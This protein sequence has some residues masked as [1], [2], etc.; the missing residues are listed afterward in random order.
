MSQLSW[1]IVVL[2]HSHSWA[3]IMFKESQWSLSHHI[4]H[5]LQ[6][7]NRCNTKQKSCNK[8]YLCEPYNVLYLFR[9]CKLGVFNL[10][11]I[12]C[13]VTMVDHI[14]ILLLFVFCVIFFS[15]QQKMQLLWNIMESEVYLYT[16]PKLLGKNYRNLMDRS[17]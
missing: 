14:F 12:A 2:L 4:L 1:C 5:H 15:S 10:E 11:S 6:H 16:R 7:L 9:L 17:A 3:P 8:P 13:C